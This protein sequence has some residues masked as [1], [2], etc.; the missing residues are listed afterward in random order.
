M[1]QKY[2]VPGPGSRTDTL[3]TGSRAPEA[4]YVLELAG[5]DDAFAIAEAAAAAESVAG[6]APGLAKAVAV[7]LDRLRGLAFTRAA[8]VLVGQTAARVESA[9]SMLADQALDRTGSVAVR[10]RD[11]RGTTGVDARVAERALGDVLTA[12]G[13]T[14]DL[15]DPDHELRALFAGSVCVLS[16]LAAESHRDYADRAPTDKPFFQPGSM[17]PIEARAVANLARVR[18]GSTVLDPMCGTGGLLVEAGLLGAR[19]V[20]IDAQWKM[21]RGARRNLAH[22]LEDWVVAQGDATRLPIGGPVEA[23]VVDVPYGR[24][25]AIA[26]VDVDTLVAGGLGEARRVAERAVVVAD[27]DR[28]SDAREA[29]WAVEAVHE[30]PVHRSLTRYVHVLSGQ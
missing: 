22:Y 11:V 2:L 23:V 14:V 7:D 6:L 9:K 15:E 24:Q 17:E 26:S 28:S 13:M 18:P 20:G 30:R 8:G 3:N 4:V 5:E 12:A 25:S 16:W 19:V 27:R 21:V 29:G 1:A 10:A